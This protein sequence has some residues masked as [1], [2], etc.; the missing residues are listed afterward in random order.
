MIV[1]HR[2]KVPQIGKHV[3]IAP[4]ATV[5]GDV[6][7]GDYCTVW[8][9][10]VIRGDY[11][12]IVIGNGT[13]IQDGAVIHGEPDIHVTIGDHVTIGHLAHIHG[14]TIESH[15]LVG[16]GAIVLDEAYV[17]THTQIAAGALVPPKKHLSTGQLYG[18]LPAKAM[19]ELRLDEL[20][21]IEKNAQHYI[22]EGQ[23]FI[24]EESH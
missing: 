13:N 7:L 2:N 9:S 21:R 15:V 23:L 8:P 19:R 11:T 24:E 1:K 10:A 5:I 16:S 3:Y 14:A 20:E 12:K 22:H 6:I 17:E 4:T 18:G